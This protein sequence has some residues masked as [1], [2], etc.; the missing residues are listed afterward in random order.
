MLRGVKTLGAGW[1]GHIKSDH[2]IY[3]G[4][5]SALCGSSNGGK[6]RSDAVL[7]SIDLIVKRGREVKMEKSNV[8]MCRRAKSRQLVIASLSLLGLVALPGPAFAGLAGKIPSPNA[9]QLPASQLHGGQVMPPSARPFGF[10]LRD[11]AGKN[12]QFVTSGNMPQFLPTTPFQFLYGDPTTISFSSLPGNGLLETGS[13][14]FRVPEGTVF[15][16]PINNID[17]SPPVIGT[18]PTSSST[19]V[20]YW[21]D[22]SQLGGSESIVVDGKTTSIGATYLVGP[23]TTQPLQDGGGTHI[24]TIGV[25]LTPLSKGSH[26]VS[27]STQLD[28]AAI[29][30]AVGINFLEG[31]FTYNVIVQ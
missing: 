31:E 22:S 29:L 17:D 15:Y 6:I 9:S 7:G 5:G 3:K 21:F 27:I 4:N 20:S 26:T 19:A 2:C 24:I 30:P 25:F 28:G 16:V 18:F 13:N 8:I 14:V 10:S 12:A 1:A 11:A 23:I